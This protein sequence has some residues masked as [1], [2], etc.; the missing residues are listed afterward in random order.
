MMRVL[1]VH[2][3]EKEKPSINDC[4]HAGLID[5]ILVKSISRFARNTVDFLRIRGLKEIGVGIIFEK[6]RFY[7]LD[8]KNETML[9]IFA[10]LAQDE[11]RQISTNV[12]WGVRAR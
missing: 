11:S 10:A 6:E 12:T 1:Q 7:S 9:S 8:D 2:A 3:L 4:D 5:L